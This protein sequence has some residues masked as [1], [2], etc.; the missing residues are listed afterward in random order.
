MDSGHIDVGSFTHR[1]THTH[2]TRVTHMV[3]DY[4]HGVPGYI[5][6]TM[7]YGHETRLPYI[8]MPYI[9]HKVS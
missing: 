1:H 7:G 8:P 4:T 6:V 2:G 3:H 9:L 5:N